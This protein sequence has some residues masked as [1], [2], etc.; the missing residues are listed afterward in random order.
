MFGGDEVSSLVLDLGTFNFRIGYS[1]EDS[2]RTV[3]QPI[4]GKNP[5]SKNLF[6]T[7]SSLRF[8]KPET[9]IISYM[10]KNGTIENY[11]LFELTI[12]NL[13]EMNMNIDLKD[14]PI[15]FS[16]PSLHNKEHRIKLTEFMFEKYQIPAIYI[17]KSAVLSSFSCGRSTCLVFDSG[18]NFTYSVPVSE[19][20]ALQKSL[21]KSDIAGLYIN[22]LVRQKIESRNIEIRP[23]YSFK[24][25][26]ID[27][28]NY[29][30]EMINNDILN[31]VDKSYEDFW[32]NEILRDLKETCLITSEEQIPYNIENDKFTVTQMVQS[33]NYE[34]PDGN[35]IELIEDR[36]LLVERVFNNIKNHIGFNGYHK[37]ISDAIS[38]TDLDIKRDLFNNIL[39]CGGNTLFYNF[40]ERLQKQLN[41]S[42]IQVKCKIISHQSNTEKKFASW[43]GGSILSSLG[44]F[45]QLWLSKQEFEEHGAMIIERKCA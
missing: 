4:I 18:H 43:I 13:L 16:E 26:K 14:H 2:P 30:I 31:K 10:N 36:M 38:K 19:G 9:K 32:K 33:I 11:D 21:L 37:M 3:F 35:T 1:G 24:K 5:N 17:C 29:E 25:N 15:I 34:L 27:N 39:I 7:E 20:Y 41:S 6:F 23:F 44:T 22:N 12:D 42:K 45:H 8:F 28:N 40:P